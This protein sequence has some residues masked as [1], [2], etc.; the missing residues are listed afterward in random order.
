[1]PG[2]RNFTESYRLHGQVGRDPS[3]YI[4]PELIAFLV[5]HKGFYLEVRNGVL[6]AFKQD[7]ELAKPDDVS[8]LFV[9]AEIFNAACYA[10]SSQR[11]NIAGV[12]P[13]N[14]GA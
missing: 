3:P 1:L 14:M 5:R 10:A 8:L 12:L 11:K 2:P 4:S 6:L 13:S 7:Q 9:L